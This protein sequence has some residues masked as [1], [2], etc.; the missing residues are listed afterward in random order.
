MDLYYFINFM[1]SEKATKFCE[2][3]TLDLTVLHMVKSKVK[4]SENFVA[5]SEYM[6]FTKQLNSVQPRDF[7]AL[8]SGLATYVFFLHKVQ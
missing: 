4:I 8:K 1:Y 3:S 2:I 7:M 5:F 6:Y